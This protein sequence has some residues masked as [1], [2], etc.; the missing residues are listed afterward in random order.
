MTKD[1]A[2]N[3]VIKMLESDNVEMQDE[4]MK[5]AYDFGIVITEIW[6]DNDDNIIGMSVEDEVIYF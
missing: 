5:I 6:D 2:I 1:K 3:K 4:A